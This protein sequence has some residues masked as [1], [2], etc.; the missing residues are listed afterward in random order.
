MQL[1]Q[2]RGHIDD[3]FFPSRRTSMRARVFATFFALSGILNAGTASA[4]II[5]IDYTG[6]YSGTTRSGNPAISQFTTTSIGPTPFSLHFRFDTA[7]SSFNSF[8][9]DTPD[10]SS[11][12]SSGAPSVGSAF[13]TF[14]VGVGGFQSARDYATTGFTSQTVADRTISKVLSNTPAVSISVSNP[15]IP[16]SITTP[17]T[18]LSGLTGSGFY[19]SVFAGNFSSFEESFTLIPQTIVVT[20]DGVGAAPVAA[21]PEPSTWAMLLFGFAGVGF[22]AYRR[23]RKEGLA[24]AA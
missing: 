13:G 22:M 14:G 18:I 17:F 23:S 3:N 4:S 12:S 24:L 5:N 11:L 8:Y 21:V 9:F 10:E 20:V 6:T 1:T 2:P 16:A 15:D 19:S 7:T